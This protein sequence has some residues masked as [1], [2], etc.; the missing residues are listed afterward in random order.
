MAVGVIQAAVGL[1][2]GTVMRSSRLLFGLVGDPAE[3]WLQSAA[4]LLSIR[5]CFFKKSMV[6]GAI[7]F[8]FKLYFPTTL[9]TPT[10][11]ITL[12]WEGQ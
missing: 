5:L 1:L 12:A 3:R 10:L 7:T 2:L 11:G 6:F 8:L 9:S 4:S